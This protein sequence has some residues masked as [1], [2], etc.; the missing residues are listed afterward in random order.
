MGTALWPIQKA[1][2]TTLSGDATL[3]ALATGVFDEVPGDQPYPYI[4]VGEGTESPLECMSNYGNED[5]VNVHI[6]DSAGPLSDHAGWKK[7]VN[8][9][10]SRMDTLLHY[11]DLTL[12]GFTPKAT[13]KYD[14]GQTLKQGNIRHFVARYRVVIMPK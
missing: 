2:Y 1:I 9:I 10:L 11:Q 8:D 12:E 14:G 13:V 6:Y 5:T 7:S 3:M 4:V